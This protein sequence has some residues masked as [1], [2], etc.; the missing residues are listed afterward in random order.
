MEES[1][2]VNFINELSFGGGIEIIKNDI[3][4]NLDFNY[5]GALTEFISAVYL[6][7][8]ARFQKTGIFINEYYFSELF[9][10]EY[11]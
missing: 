9:I 10:F 11:G 4:N 8:K 1:M 3:I 6:K 7:F 2:N 5:I